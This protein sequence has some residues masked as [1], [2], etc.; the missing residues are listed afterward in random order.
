MLEH[1][2]RTGASFDVAM[3]DGAGRIEIESVEALLPFSWESHNSR[4]SQDQQS[5][6]CREPRLLPKPAGAHHFRTG[7]CVQWLGDKTEAIGIVWES[8]FLPGEMLIKMKYV[9]TPSGEWLKQPHSMT[10][11]FDY[12]DRLRKA[13]FA[14]PTAFGPSAC[15]LKP[16]DVE[17]FG[18]AGIEGDAKPPEEFL[19]FLGEADIDISRVRFTA[20]RALGME[21]EDSD[22][23]ILLEVDTENILRFRK[24]ARIWLENGKAA[25]P[26]ES[27]TWRLFDKVFP[28]G[29]K[30]IIEEDRFFESLEFGGKKVSVIFTREERSL[31]YTEEEWESA[32]WRTI[33]GV[34]TEDAACTPFKRACFSL[35]TGFQKPVGVVSYYKFA[36]LVKP[37]DRLSLGGWLLHNK[38]KGAIQRLVQILPGYDPIVW[39]S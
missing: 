38:K 26:K 7:D 39:L 21:Q 4:G 13:G 9:K 32:G 14:R 11:P 34:V 16:S 37:G 10:E 2:S 35:T 36:N 19:R 24:T 27:G 23:D 5:L 31:I 17:G 33:S 6:R 3:V 22:F 30:R 15:L 28:G 1:V 29:S 12:M 8:D 20:S 25:V 18:A